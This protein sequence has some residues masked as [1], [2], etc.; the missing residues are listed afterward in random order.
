MTEA[1]WLMY[2][3]LRNGQTQPQKKELVSPYVIVTDSNSSSW[4]IG[5]PIFSS[6]NR[7]W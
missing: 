3:Q 4:S 1:M 6:I 2:F 5:P 7:G